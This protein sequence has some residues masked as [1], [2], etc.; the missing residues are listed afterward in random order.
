[1]DKGPR[2]VSPRRRLTPYPKPPLHSLP[3]SVKLLALRVNVFH[4]KNILKQD[5]RHGEGATRVG[6]G[7]SARSRLGVHAPPRVEKRGAGER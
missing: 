6:K 7:L 3:T 1:M 5:A 2:G 4:V